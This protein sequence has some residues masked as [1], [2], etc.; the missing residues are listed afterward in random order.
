MKLLFLLALSAISY[1]AQVPSRQPR[2]LPSPAGTIGTAVLP[3][4]LLDQFKSL[5]DAMDTSSIPQIDQIKKRT[6]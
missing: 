5:I 1:G 2:P 3:Q 4:E 6:E